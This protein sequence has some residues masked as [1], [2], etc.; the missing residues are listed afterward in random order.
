[1]STCGRNFFLSSLI[2][3]KGNLSSPH[4]HISSKR[5]SSHPNSSEAASKK[6]KRWEEPKMFAFDTCTAP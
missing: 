5:L 1:K 3:N 4:D 2:N 6:I